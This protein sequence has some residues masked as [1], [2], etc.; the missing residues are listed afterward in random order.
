MP[1]YS[2]ANLTVKIE[3]A[4]GRIVTQAQPYLCKDGT[5]DIVIT[6]DENRVN[7]AVAEHLELNYSDWEY[8]ITGDDF[9][10]QLLNFNGIM[11]HASCVVYNGR[12][13]AFSASSG[14]G[15]TTHTKLWLKHLDG[16]YI[17]NDDK[18][19]IRVIDGRLCACGTPWSGRDDISRPEIV[20]LDSIC[21]I[22]RA[23]ENRIEVADTQSA[24]FK[25]F[26][27]TIRK[28]G[29]QGMEKLF[30]VLDEMFK[31]ITFY[32]LFCDMSDEA[33]EVA[34]NELIKE[35]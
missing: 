35:K 1:L 30:D 13:Y 17:L 19:A 26:S 18:P 23:K 12:A 27:Q 34:Y 20:P 8:M 31:N 6:V 14:V 7:K 32:N 10:R 5:A 15:K 24:V 25:I 11:L 9:Y 3:N 2:I 21:F 28:L 33:F 22:E 29:E 16:A 4:K